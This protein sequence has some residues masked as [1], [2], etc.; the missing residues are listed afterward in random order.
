MGA[1]S[2]DERRDSGVNEQAVTFRGSSRDIDGF[3]A[4]PEKPG[5]FPAVIV[6]HEIWGLDDHIRSVA[7]RFAR[8]GFVALAPD[9]YTGELSA[10][11]RPER[12]AS[13]MAVLREAP[14]EVQR[15]PERLRPFLEQRRPEER[16]ALLTLMEVMRPQ[17]REGFARDLLGALPFL[18]ALPEVQANRIACLGFCMGGGITALV[19][20]LAPDLWKAVIFYGE[21][22]PL[23][24]VP[25]IRAEVL[26]IYGGEDP[27]ITE[28]VPEFAAAMTAHGKAFRY[29]VYEGARHAFFND[30]RP[31]YHHDASRDAW[32][33]TLAFLRS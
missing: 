33:R 31:M 9:L 18:A 23:E 24:K 2:K 22:P 8:E 21:N 19:A 14:P 25:D 30:T 29:H 4:M 7:R 17:T 27:R 28:H 5:T 20:T 13:G 11:M 12:I 26:G 32:E 3:L 15:D 6:V 10:K 16:E 1:A